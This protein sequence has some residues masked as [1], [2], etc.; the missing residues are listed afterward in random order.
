MQISQQIRA[1]VA[2]GLGA[3]VVH[4]GCLIA[5][6]EAAHWQAV[7]A[8]LV[9]YVA[10]GVVSYL[11]NKRLTFASK[12]AHRQAVWRFIVVASVG[13]CLTW[14]AMRVLTGQF[15][16]PYLPAQIL[17]TGMVLVWSFVANKLWTFGV[18]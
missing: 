5:L 1:F 16:F 4:Y 6:V 8:T 7:P 3:A 12:R 10:G 18:R 13:F 9:G 2:V 14:L 17:T 15:N 11:L